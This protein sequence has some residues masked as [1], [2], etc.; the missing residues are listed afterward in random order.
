MGKELGLDVRHPSTQPLVRYI[1]LLRLYPG[2][3]IGTV[4]IGTGVI[5]MLTHKHDE[6]PKIPELLN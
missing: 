4:R 1:W 5:G 3:S 2:S 6:M